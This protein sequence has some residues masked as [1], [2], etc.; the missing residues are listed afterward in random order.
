LSRVRPCLLGSYDVLVCSWESKMG[1][2]KLGRPPFIGQR[3]GQPAVASSRRSHWA[4]IKSGVLPW[5]KAPRVRGSRGC[6]VVSYSLWWT[7]RAVWGP[8]AIIW[9]M[10]TPVLR[11]LGLDV[12]HHVVPCQRYAHSNLVSVGHECVACQGCVGHKCSMV[13]RACRLQVGRR[14]T[15]PLWLGDRRR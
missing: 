8:S 12:V 9:S 15:P 11:S 14:P 3:G 1:G 13:L 7:T 2:P 6:L 4:M 10:P 5:G